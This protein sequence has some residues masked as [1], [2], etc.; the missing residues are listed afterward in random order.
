[1]LQTRLR[2]VERLVMRV[3]IVELQGWSKFGFRP[4]S[5]LGFTDPPN[6]NLVAL[7]DKSFLSTTIRHYLKTIP[8]QPSG[9]RVGIVIFCT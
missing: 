6:R 2:M 8:T 3:Y 9:P 4:Q 1:M 5:M 7:H